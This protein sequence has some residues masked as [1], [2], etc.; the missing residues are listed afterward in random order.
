MYRKVAEV[1]KKYYDDLLVSNGTKRSIETKILGSQLNMD[2]VEEDGQEDTD[3]EDKDDVSG[4][5]CL[6]DANGGGVRLADG[7]AGGDLCRKK[8]H[9]K[10]RCW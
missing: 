2:E 1:T 5:S 8:G 3:G 10:C 9:I 6:D 7:T 4:V